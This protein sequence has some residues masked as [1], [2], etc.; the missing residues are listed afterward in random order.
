MWWY[1]L[2]KAGS[3]WGVANLVDIGAVEGGG[4]GWGKCHSG[5]EDNVDSEYGTCER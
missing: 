5:T 1:A 4:G 2:I 3:V